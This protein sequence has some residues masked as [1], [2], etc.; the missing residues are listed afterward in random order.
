[1]K[2]KTIVILAN[3]H[4]VLYKFRGEL[5]STL[6]NAGYRVVLM[7]PYGETVDIMKNWGCEYIDVPMLSRHRKNVVEEIQLIN[8]YRKTFCSLRPDLILSYTIKP[9]LYGGMV[10]T[11]LKIPFIASIT[12]LGMSIENR[13]VLQK[14]VKLMYSICL[15]RAY[16]TFAQNNKIKQFLLERKLSGKIVLVPGSGVNLE[17]HCYE[18][19][20]LSKD[21]IVFITVGRLM[22][23]KGIDELLSA[24]R[25]IKKQYPQIRF[26]LIG[27]DDGNYKEI[28][29]DAEKDK[30]VEYYGFQDNAH[31]WIA[32]SHAII[33]A[34]YHEGMANVLLESAAI[35]RPII[36]T[37]IEGCRETFEEGISGIG[38]KVRDAEDLARAIRDFIELPYEQ[39]VAMGIAGRR[40]MEKEFDRNIVVKAYLDE[41]KSLIG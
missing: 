33:H 1:M 21:E 26:Q 2:K 6:L 31:D 15:K 27:F 20:P 19:Y 34:S 39:K 12:G 28:V 41:I 24:A 32:K 11:M 8:M 37:N 4:I 7:L 13:G 5:I 30:I 35:G 10:A 14:I 40:K 25:M 23:D 38:C 36:A 16:C 17:K 3:H 18:E 9:N 22:K 29:N